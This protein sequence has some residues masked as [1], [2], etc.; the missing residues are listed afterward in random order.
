MDPA[1]PS[2]RRWIGHEW[3]V[4]LV[5]AIVATLAFGWLGWQFS[6]V[7]HRRAMWLQINANGG[8]SPGETLDWSHS[9][10]PDTVRE[11][12]QLGIPK[13][14]RLMGDTS[15]PYITFDHPLTAGDR[16]AIQAFPE[17]RIYGVLGPSQPAHLPATR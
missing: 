2:R 9:I 1:E 7:V 10:G 3:T 6:I 16:E 4:L 8:W 15:S 14:R 5:I 12:E 13:I 11:S 17:A